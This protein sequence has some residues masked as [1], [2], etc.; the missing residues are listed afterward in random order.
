MAS[1]GIRKTP[2][3][4]H[5][6]WWRL[7]D[8]TKGSLTFD[9]RDQARDFKHDLL[10]RLT[11]G[12]WVDP[13]LGKQTFEA[14]ARE[15]WELWSRDPDRS[16]ATLQA[17]E[18]RLRRYLL[19]FFGHHQLR[20]VTV[21]MVR[22]W[23]NDL[24]GKLAHEMV[25]ACRSVLNRI[26]QAAEDDRRIDA[27]PVRKVTAPKPPVDPD[28]LLGRA[29]RRSYTPE[30]FGLLLAAARPWCRDHFLTLAGTGMRP[31][32]LLGLRARRVD[33]AAR[34]LEVLEVRYE[35]GRFGSGYKD[36]PKSATSIR[37]IPLAAQVA[38]AVGR[39][40][41]AGSPPDVLVFTGPGGGSGVAV[42][43]RTALSRDNLRRVYH[44][45]LARAV[46]MTT[47]LANTP[48]RVLQALR[49]AGPGQ[50]PETLRACIPGV[51]PTAHTVHAALCE[52]R[53]AGLATLGPP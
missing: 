44:A 32:E 27:N 30:E 19:P 23:Q 40:L 41:P 52:L 24:R 37:V 10:A 47:R 15:W 9:S 34:R 12:T 42:G 17:T 46:D 29:K 18:A 14:W 35:A 2:T 45:A 20:A 5:K 38:E 7:D 4:R 1:A 51:T 8:G 53:A 50:I 25:M 11:R 16:P 43:T 31:G 33:L 28:A 49:Q 36:R 26:L 21:S 22:R 6:V 13:R 39:Q 48:R 3:G